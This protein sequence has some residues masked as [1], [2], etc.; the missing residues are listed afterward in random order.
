MKINP[1]VKSEYYRI[2]ALLDGKTPSRMELFRLMQEPQYLLC[3]ENAK[4]NIFKHYLTALAELDELCEAELEIQTGIG[5]EFLY[6]LE[7]TRMQKS[8]KMVILKAFLQ[9]GTLKMAITE[10]EV[11]DTWKA[12]FAEGENWKDL[13]VSSYQ[14]FLKITEEQH[15]ANAE[16]NPIHFLLSSGKGFFMERPGYALAL[17]EHLKDVVTSEI[18]VRHFED[19]VAYRTAEYFRKKAIT[20]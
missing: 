1:F 18:V 12:F 11:L 8:Y 4:E 20:S 13:G 16:K 15:L 2:K 19:I 10:Q 6:L 3:I 14:E 5:G 7:N 9:D 17:S